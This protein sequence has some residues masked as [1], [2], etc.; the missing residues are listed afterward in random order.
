M[1][2]E[3]LKKAIKAKIVDLEIAMSLN[4]PSPGTSKNL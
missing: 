1:T 3:E 2:P 4:R